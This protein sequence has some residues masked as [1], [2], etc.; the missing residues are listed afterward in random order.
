MGHD[1]KQVFQTDS[2]RRWKIFVWTAR[3]IIALLLLALGTIIF[4]FIK[5]SYPDLPKLIGVSNVE[6]KPL[7]KTD[8]PNE[9]KRYIKK[10]PRRLIS[11]KEMKRRSPLHSTI[12]AAFYVNWDIQSFNALQ[13]HIDDLN[14]VLPEWLSI[15]PNADTIVTQIQWNAY[16]MMDSS[17]AKIIPLLSNFYNDQWHDSCVTRM[18]ASRK[19]RSVFI[20]N[21]LTVIQRYGFDGV[22][23][24]FEDLYSLTDDQALVDFHKEL[25]DSLHAHNLLA[26]QCIP[27]FNADY[28]VSDLH[29]FNDYIFVMAYDQHFMTTEPGP[30]SGAKWVEQVLDV[31]TE[32]IQPE[33]FVLCIAGYGYDWLKGGTGR[34]VSYQ[35]A[36]STARETHAKID[37]DN[38]N[39]NVHYTYFDD[40]QQEHEVWF[41][42]A[43]TNYNVMRTASE[44]GLAGVAL[45]R[46]NAEDPRIWSFYKKDL[47]KDSLSASPADIEPLT[48]VSASSDVDFIGDRDAQILDVLAW[49]HDGKTKLEYNAKEQ[50]ISEETY[51]ELPSSYVIKKIGPTT[52]KQ[53]VLTFDDGPDAR[54][55][56]KVMEI[57]KRENVPAAFFMIGENMQ[58]NLPLVRKVY[59]AGYEIGN[60]TFTHPN[61]SDI[62]KL[63]SKLELNATRRLLEII[64]DHSTVLF[65]PPFNSDVLSQ[66]LSDILPVAESRQEN[67]LTVGE[68]IDP[69]DWKQGFTVD[70]IMNRIY[71]AENKN[72]LVLLH[73]A[74][75]DRSATVAALPKIIA[76]YR[77]QGYQFLSIAQLVGKSKNDLMPAVV[78]RKQNFINH[79]NYFI[80][81]SFFRI[82][83]FIFGIFFV[84]I[85]LAMGRI[86]FIAIL[87]I[88]QH[89]KAKSIV[90]T[91]AQPRVSIIV[92]AYNEGVNAVKTVNNLLQADYPDYEIIFVNDGSKDDTLECVTASF[93]DNE[94]VKIFDKPNGGKASALNYGM[95]RASGEFVVCI[96]ADTQLKRDAVSRLMESFTGEDVA[97]VAGNVKVGN[98]V[99]MLTKWQSIEYITAQN[100]DRQAF[101]MLNCI[102]VVPGA[103]GAFRKSAVKEAG[104]FTSDT[105]AEDC[106]LTVRILRVG[107]RVTTNNSA[108]AMTESPEV[109]QEFLR[110]RFRWSFGVMQTFW[111]NKAVCFNK[112]YKALGLI[113]FPNILIFQIVLPFLSPLVDF[114]MF[115]GLLYD[116][117]CMAGLVN[118]SFQVASEHAMQIGLYYSI[119]QIIDLLSAMLAFNF[120]KEKFSKLWLLI[121][122]RFSYRF[123]MYHVLFKS[124]RRAM[125]GELQSWGVLK[126]TGNVQMVEEEI[127]SA[128]H[129]RP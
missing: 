121:P 111:K 89:R 37:F 59:D 19:K 125:K 78:G 72:G 14:V 7:K 53:I 60:H 61:L 87:A 82:Q 70:S 18:V 20:S 51:L 33:K 42:D 15:D 30:V 103:I 110:Q 73:D 32:K 101:D 117:V 27:P 12:R 77:S 90:L 96:D 126:R 44:F 6:F 71:N 64:T 109:L 113:A 119:F 108:I 100:F 116:F 4:A 11:E 112:K 3:S 9:F 105:L 13:K 91:K 40:K 74:G 8:K 68:S 118:G 65:R 98:E 55:T 114:V 2:P 17:Q 43:A 127:N 54:Y 83:H 49:P 128:Y 25:Y 52:E 46:L 102:T 79:A 104:G 10:K 29:K 28:R 80:A 120:E 57:L 95:E 36:I 81:D 1:S 93:A 47:S 31:F 22:S 129:V 75:G 34:A 69:Q 115:T 123:L 58:N 63:R 45:W 92:P 38:E 66:K 76:Y 23:V 86:I 48:H 85:F 88:M 5:N 107:Y 84:A 41:A 56:P 50:L 124:V 26:T 35:E 62:S 21:L 97:A 122:Q 24:D 67:Y 94:K 16:R 99:N 39:Y 106:D